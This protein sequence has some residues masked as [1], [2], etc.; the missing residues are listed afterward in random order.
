MKLPK[1]DPANNRRQERAP[2]A[3]DKNRDTSTPTEKKLSDLYD[4]IND[5]EVAMLTT[6]RA[7]GDLVSRPMH[8][9]KERLDEADLWFVTSDQTHKLDELD[10][11]PHVNL[12]YVRKH[13]GDWVSVSGT[14]RISKDRSL[15]H[16]LYA[17]SWRAWFGDEGGNRD[18]GRDDPRITL[19][20]V[21]ARSVMYL[22]QTHSKPVVL[23]QVARGAVTGEPP[24]AGD[25]RHVSRSE[26]QHRPH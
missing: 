21:D 23:F 9:Q 15:I 4:L 2:N 1:L 22:K 14:A 25:L 7:D 26:M 3:D 13:G 10:T 5:I 8:P 16:R 19:I 24:K 6:R 20:P 11:D 12:A 17:K 18:G